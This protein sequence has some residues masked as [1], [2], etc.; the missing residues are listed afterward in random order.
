MALTDDDLKKIEQLMDKQTDK[1]RVDWGKDLNR[2][3]EKLEAIDIKSGTVDSRL[4]EIATLFRQQV[5]P[6]ELRQKALEMEV[7]ALRERVDKLDP[8]FAK[9]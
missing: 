6:T 3:F 8:P 9:H 4:E 2:I 1:L 7:Q 5:S